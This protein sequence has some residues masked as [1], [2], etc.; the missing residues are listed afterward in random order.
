MIAKHLATVAAIVVS[1]ALLCGAAAPPSG[2][3]WQTDLE[4]AKRIAAQTNRLALVHFWQRNCGPCKQ[5]DQDV[6]SQSQVQQEIQSRFVPVKLNAE[7]WPTTLKTYG[8]TRFPT[9]LV[10]TP[11]G[12]IVGRMT[13]PLKPDIYLQQLAIAA[14]GTGPAATPGASS[15]VASMAGSATPTSMASAPVVQPG[16]QMIPSATAPVAAA[17]TSAAW[18][19]MQPGAAQQP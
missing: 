2:I 12:Q 3:L 13:S 15:Y 18:G 11:S 8:I 17:Q 19:P 9:D 1:C 7:E 14:S 6:F 4:A 5:L 10:I 16:T